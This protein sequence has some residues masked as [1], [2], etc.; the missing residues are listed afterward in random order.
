[1]YK[2]KSASNISSLILILLWLRLG[3]IL[4]TSIHGI[5]LVW[6]VGLWLFH[7]RR[8]TGRWLNLLSFLLLLS[9]LFSYTSI[10]VSLSVLFL[11]ILQVQSQR[12]EVALENM[13]WG[14]SWP[15]F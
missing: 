13:G 3:Q 6:W 7:W 10:G 11:G 1:M 14:K 4:V 5:D 12:D 8:E 9:G 15:F 2:F